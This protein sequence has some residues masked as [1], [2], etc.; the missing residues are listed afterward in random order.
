LNFDEVEMIQDVFDL[1]VMILD[2]QGFLTTRFLLLSHGV[3][4]KE[5]ALVDVYQHPCCLDGG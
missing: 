5:R 2:G 4:E 3:E 1:G